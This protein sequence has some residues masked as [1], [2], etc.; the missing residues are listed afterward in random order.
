M[1]TRFLVL[2]TLLLCCTCAAAAEAVHCLRGDSVTGNVRL[3]VIGADVGSQM[4]ADAKAL[5]PWEWRASEHERKRQPSA[6]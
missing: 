5:P 1:A 2:V 6:Q 4:L 3:Q